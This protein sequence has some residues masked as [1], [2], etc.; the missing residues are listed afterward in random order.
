VVVFENKLM[1]I[2][3]PK[4]QKVRERSRK[5]QTEVIHNLYAIN[6]RNKKCDT[7]KTHDKHEKFIQICTQKTSSE[8]TS[9][10][11]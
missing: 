9:Y 8:E 5:L 2:F 11:T 3:E 4:G 6:E 10:Q 1:R 7:Y